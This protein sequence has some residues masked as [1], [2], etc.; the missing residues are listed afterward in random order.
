MTNFLPE[1]FSLNRNLSELAYIIGALRDGCFTEIK[2]NYIYRIRVYQKDKKWILQL[3]EKFQWLFDKKPAI[4]FDN[5]KNVFN[6]RLDSKEIYKVITKVAEYPGN[7]K[8]WNTPKWILKSPQKIQK[9]Y[10][11][12]FF[13]AEGG[14]PHVEKREIKPTNIRVHFSQGNKK[15]LVELKKMINNFGIKT[16]SVCGPYFKKNYKDPQYALMIHGIKEVTQ[17]YQ[18]FGSLHSLKIKRLSIIRKMMK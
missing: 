8:Q 18:I 14:I 5:R 3:A 15:S 10:V 11:R 6:L 12:G 2:E 4:E 16:G 7:Q 1:Q 9:E 17:F 13:D